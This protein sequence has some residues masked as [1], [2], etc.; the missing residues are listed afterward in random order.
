MKRNLDE[1]GRISYQSRPLG[2]VT[3]EMV[4][5][6]AQEIAII[7]GRSSGEVLDSDLDEA[8]RELTGE[9]DVPED[10]KKVE[11]V[12]ET[13]RWDP[14]PGTSGEK[15][16][17]ES[18]DDEQSVSEKLTQEGLEDAEHDQMVKGTIA[19]ARRDQS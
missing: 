7:N 12:P 4:R 14:V 15:L 6:R 19:E 2:T 5:K 10:Q 18:A 8:Q 1:E 3:E 11:S 17:D 13:Q 16:P 9:D